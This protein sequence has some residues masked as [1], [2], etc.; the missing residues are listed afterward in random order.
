M[1]QHI[2]ASLLEAQNALTALLSDHATLQKIADATDV[3]VKCLQNGGRILSCGNGGSMC[4][5]MHFAEELT[6]RYRDNRK[7]FSAMAM[8]DASHLSCTAN[9][10]GYAQV[11]ARYAQAH[12][13]PGDCLLAFSTSG[14]SENI[15]QA[16]KWCSENEMKVIALTGQGDSPLSKFSHININTPAGKY[17]DRIQELHIKLVHIFIENIERK[18]VPE[19][20]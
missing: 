15:I 12:G 20:Y 17:A 9:D 19:N 4:D 2:T 8:S 11:F 6:G 1:I 18:L 10:Y 14:K 5:A 7:A 3:M 13:R 16:A